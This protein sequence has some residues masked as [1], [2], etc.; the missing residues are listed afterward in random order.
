MNKAPLLEPLSDDD[1]DALAKLLVER[2][3][4][5]VDALLGLLHAVAVAPGSVPPPTWLQ[6]VLPVGIREENPGEAETLT[7]LI[8]RLHRQV[9]LAL[10]G[11]NTIIPEADDVARC[12]A[13]ADGFLQGAAADPAWLDDDERWTF[14]SWAAYLANKRDLIAPALLEDLDDDA[15]S[16]AILRKQMGSIIVTTNEAFLALRQRK[17]GA[18]TTTTSARRP[19]RNDPCACGSGKKYKRCCASGAGPQG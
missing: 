9:L 3:P 18:A 12:A 2:S 11:R 5:D 13:F 17:A 7:G 10:E 19:G 8:L 16:K 4:F 14:A 6:L 15:G 1:L